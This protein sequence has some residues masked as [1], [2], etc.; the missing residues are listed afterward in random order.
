MAAILHTAGKMMRN[1]IKRAQWQRNLVV[2]FSKCLLAVNLC[3]INSE[4]YDFMLCAARAS[5]LRPFFHPRATL[6]SLFKHGK[7]A[8]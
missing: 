6:A 2:W 7:L 1:R 8:V 5:E 3:F 4:R